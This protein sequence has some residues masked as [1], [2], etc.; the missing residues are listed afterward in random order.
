M[1]GHV[2]VLFVACIAAIGALVVVHAQARLNQRDAAT[3]RWAQTAAEVLAQSALE[4]GLADLRAKRALPTAPFALAPGEATVER[5][6][7]G[8]KGCGTV[9]ARR[10]CLTAPVV[11]GELGRITI[12]GR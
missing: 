11:E 1:K 2:L 7:D 5:T 4:R 6:A 10:I 9:K 12:A 8:L 3:V